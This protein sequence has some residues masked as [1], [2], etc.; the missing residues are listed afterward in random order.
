MS[1]YVYFKNIYY[2]KDSLTGYTLPEIDL[3]VLSRKGFSNSAL[4]YL[5]TTIGVLLDVSDIPNIQMALWNSKGENI[6]IYKLLTNMAEKVGNFIKPIVVPWDAKIALSRLSKLYNLS[7][8]VI[9]KTENDR[10]LITFIT[11]QLKMILDKYTRLQNEYPDLPAN[12]IGIDDFA[13]KGLFDITNYM[14][15][16]YYGFSRYAVEYSYLIGDLKR[17]G[18]EVSW[19]EFSKMEK[20]IPYT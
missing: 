5:M 17:N 12:E 6:R 7:N 4:E 16:Q 20:S 13:F 8:N 1:Q 11:T 9:I 18:E 10:Q 14:D 2:G 15:R 19:E 3:K